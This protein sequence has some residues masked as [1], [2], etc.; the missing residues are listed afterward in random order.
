METKLTKVIC[1]IAGNFE[2]ENSLNLAVT[3]V[4]GQHI[5]GNNTLL[6]SDIIHVDF[7]MLPTQRF[8]QETV[9]FSFWF[10]FVFICNNDIGIQKKKKKQKH[11]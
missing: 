4:V 2:A 9:S 5:Y 8:R 6:H 1:Y 11:T 3:A 10:Y 7:A